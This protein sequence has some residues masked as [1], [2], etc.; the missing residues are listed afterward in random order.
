MY[1]EENVNNEEICLNI[2]LFN[3]PLLN[4]DKN[5]PVL[6]GGSNRIKFLLSL[7]IKPKG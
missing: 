4:I 5:Q 2:L 6:V 1:I 3:R 7:T